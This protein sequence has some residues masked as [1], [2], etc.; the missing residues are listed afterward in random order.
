MRFKLTNRGDRKVASNENNAANNLT[1][2]Y[3]EALLKVLADLLNTFEA[4]IR[5]AKDELM[6][7]AQSMV[8]ERKK[9][10]FVFPEPLLKDAGFEAFLVKVLE[11]TQAKHPD[12]SY[13][14]QRNEQGEIVS[15]EFQGPQESMKL[16]LGA[17]DWIRRKILAQK[18]VE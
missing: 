7:I 8:E 15:V 9:A 10:T 12:F 11:V 13:R 5:Q 17:C 18:E 6:K 2:S 1:V 16:V 14:L 4:G 3:E